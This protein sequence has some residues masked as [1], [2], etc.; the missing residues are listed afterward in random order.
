LVEFG[1]AQ[2][3]LARPRARLLHR[4]F[5]QHVETGLVLPAGGGAM[6]LEV[7]GI[8]S[9]RLLLRESGTR[10][11]KGTYCQSTQ[12]KSDLPAASRHGQSS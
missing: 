7:G 12:E 3:R 1:L 2:D 9:W 5:P 6:L 8:G 4:L 11:T 10:N